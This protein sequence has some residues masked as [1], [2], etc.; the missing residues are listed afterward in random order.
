MALNKKIEI[1]LFIVASIIVLIWIG[2]TIQ[3]KET[4]SNNLEILINETT[5]LHCNITPDCENKINNLLIQAGRAYVE[6]SNDSEKREYKAM[7]IKLRMD[8]LNLQNLAQDSEIS[9]ELEEL[10]KELD[11]YNNTQFFKLYKSL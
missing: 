7:M 1:A 8:S 6:T 5:N 10:Q 3:K 2:T 4:S 11:S 9:L